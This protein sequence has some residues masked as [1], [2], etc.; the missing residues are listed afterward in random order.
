MASLIHWQTLYPFIDILSP[1]LLRRLRGLVSL[2]ESKLPSDVF[3]EFE[4]D[5]AGVL[6]EGPGLAQ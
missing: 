6:A 4:A 5:H 1:D 2:L 3:A